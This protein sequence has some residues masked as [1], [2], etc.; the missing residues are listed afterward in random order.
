MKLWHV[1]I[2]LAVPLAACAGEEPPPEAAPIAEHPTAT[3]SAL[4]Q[5]P[6]ATPNVGAADNKAN[7]VTVAP[8][9]TPAP[10]KRIHREADLTVTRLVMAKGVKSREPVEAGELFELSERLYA[11]VEVGNAEQ[12]ESEI[13]VSFTRPNRKATGRIRLRVGESPRWRTWAYTRL[14][15]TTGQWEAV[16]SNADGK[17]LARRSFEIVDKK[18]AEVSVTDGDSIANP[19]TGPKTA[20]KIAPKAAPKTEAKV[21]PKVPSAPTEP[22]AQAS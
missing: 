7:T 14:A 9:T 13:Y 8:N 17:V 22:P 10:E 6:D 4:P 18:P 19:T 16:V 2:A 21:E 20:P 5:S 1:A 11:F 12:L 15:N 3:P